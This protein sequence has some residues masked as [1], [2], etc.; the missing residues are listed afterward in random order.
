[1]GGNAAAD[2]APWQVVRLRAILCAAEAHSSAVDH[3][4]AWRLTNPN[5]S[6]SPSPSPNPSP[7]PSPSPNPNQVG[8]TAPS[9][10]ES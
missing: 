7:D 1:M 8:L 2:A 10:L 5:P 6:P 9:T 3:R 4:H